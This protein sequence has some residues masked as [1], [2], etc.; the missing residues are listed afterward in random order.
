M[1]KN[2]IAMV[3]EAQASYQSQIVAA[4]INGEIRDIQKY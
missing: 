2:L 4:K 1:E 3:S